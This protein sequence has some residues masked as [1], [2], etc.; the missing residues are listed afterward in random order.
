MGICASRVLKNT[1]ME[2]PKYSFKGQTKTCKVVDVYDGDT[3]DVNMIFDNRVVRMKIRLEG[4]DTPEMRPRK[5]KPEE[6]EDVKGAER[7]RDDEVEAAKEAKKL[8]KL[9][10]L[11]RIVKLKCGDFGKYGRLLGTIIIDKGNLVFP[12]KINVNEYMLKS[13]Y[14]IPYDGGTKIKWRDW[15]R[16]SESEKDIC[17]DRC[18]QNEN[19]R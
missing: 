18:L 17:I 4:F 19:F 16:K 14:G 2:V 11:N 10:I 5:V 1:D 3:V 9:A 7:E 12:N 13:G 6:V 8:L 15:D